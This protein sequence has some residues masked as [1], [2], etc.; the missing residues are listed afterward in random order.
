VHR[1]D[2]AGTVAHG[3]RHP[4]HRRPAHVA[5]RED[6]RLARLVGQRVPAEVPPPPAEDVGCQL[7][8][9]RDEPALVQCDVRQPPGRRLRPDEA[10]QPRAVDPVRGPIAWSS[11]AQALVHQDDRHRRGD[12][13]RTPR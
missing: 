1:T 11:S 12:N 2:R 10:E 4:F 9:G 3:R 7:A 13:S 5:R 8:V 6:T